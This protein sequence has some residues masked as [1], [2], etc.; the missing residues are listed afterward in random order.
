MPKYEIIN[1]SD[2]AFI[3]GDDFKALCIATIFLGDGFYGL[4]EENGDQHMPP[5]AFSKNWYELQFGETFKESL[6]K[7]D[8]TV[9][10]TIFKTVRLEGERS[11]L[12]DIV[13]R[14]EF[15][16]SRFEQIVW[17]KQRNPCSN[18]CSK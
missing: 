7:L 11:S 14:A 10:C 18:P 4:Q 6:T 3:E 1:P 2:K 17:D 13:G 16:A 12:T 5:V 15:L 8:P 9:M